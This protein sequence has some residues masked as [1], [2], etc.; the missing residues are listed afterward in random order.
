MNRTN[1]CHLPWS[2]AAIFPDEVIKPC[3]RF[4]APESFISNSS[5]NIEAARNSPMFMNTREQMLSGSLP[6]SCSKCRMEEC[7]GQTSLLQKSNQEHDLQAIKDTK[8]KNL[9]SIEWFLGNVC[10]LRCITCAPDRSSSWNQDAEVVGY[11]KSA[12][13]KLGIDELKKYL[14]KLKKIKLIGGEPLLH[15]EFEQILEEVILSGNSNGMHIICNSNR[16]LFP[17]EKILSLLKK[18]KLIE[19]DLSLDGIGNVNEYIRHPT[20]CIKVEE[21]LNKF[22]E[23][24]Q[25]QKNVVLY[26]TCTISAYNTMYIAEIYDWWKT[27]IKNLKSQRIRSAICWNYVL[28]PKHM[29]TFILPQ[30]MREISITEIYKRDQIFN[31]SFTSIYYEYFSFR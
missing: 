23:L 20:K 3:C 28:S 12:I 10:N 1:L 9:E 31:K 14:P 4:Q 2:H 25:N 29:S 11:K 17:E 15:K 27:R 19:L 6:E 5:I 30:Q 18:F 8:I 7:A 24:A 21:N 13:K 26:I 22:I 16:T